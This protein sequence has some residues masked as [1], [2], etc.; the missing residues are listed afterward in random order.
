MNTQL[1]ELH[2]TF[3]AIAKTPEKTHNYRDV[4]QNQYKNILTKHSRLDEINS[5]IYW[6]HEV[7]NKVRN[8]VR[9]LI[10]IEAYQ[11][12]AEVGYEIMLEEIDWLS[13]KNLIG[14]AEY[15]EEILQKCYQ[16]LEEMMQP[17]AGI[18]NMVLS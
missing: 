18:A 13:S 3:K 2:T 4:L 17:E 5:L 16:R 12:A 15:N 14:R 1:A 9:K 11:E 8:V 6:L 10:D 7:K